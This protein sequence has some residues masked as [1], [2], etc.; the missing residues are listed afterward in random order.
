MQYKIGSVYELN[1]K[2][3]F[4][5]IETNIKSVIDTGTRCY[6]VNV[7]KAL[8][9]VT[10]DGCWNSID[11][12]PHDFAK[13]FKPSEIVNTTPYIT[14]WDVDINQI[15]DFMDCDSPLD[16]TMHGKV[17]C[18]ASIPKRKPHTVYLKF[19]DSES[20]HSFDV[21]VSNTLDQ[22]ML[23]ATGNNNIKPVVTEL[24]LQ[25]VSATIINYVT[26]YLHKGAMTLE[27]FIFSRQDL[28][29]RMF[30]ASTETYNLYAS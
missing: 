18:R 11:I 17:I 20:Q 25:L 28:Y 9:V 30:D 21:L 10:L 2:I 4:A 13:L 16:I 29:I 19:M 26:S 3:S 24:A 5:S 7:D 12:G 27:Q 14:E 6:L 15:D 23:R 22:I 1:H 8:S